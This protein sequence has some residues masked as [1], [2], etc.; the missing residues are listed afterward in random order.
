MVVACSVPDKR[1]SEQD[2]EMIGGDGDETTSEGTTSDAGN[3]LPRDAP[4]PSI[5]APVPSVDAGP[6]PEAE[7]KSNGNG[8]MMCD[9]PPSE[10]LD[11]LFLLRYTDAQCVAKRCVYTR[12]IVYCPGGCSNGACN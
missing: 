8:A 9:V 5:D 4:A 7:C 2:D 12:E 11:A 10:C 1:Q 3:Q 6:P